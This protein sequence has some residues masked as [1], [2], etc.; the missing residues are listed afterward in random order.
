MNS[1]LRV[2]MITSEWPSPTSPEA[3]SAP[4]V[5]RQVDFLRQSGIAVEVF[6]FQG[7]KKLSNYLRAWYRVQ[8]RLSERKFDLVHAQFGQSAFPAL[9]KRLPLVI[10]F[11][12]SDLEGIVGD[13]GRYTLDGWGLRRF[14]Q[15][16]ARMADWVIVV[17]EHM[18][19]HL[20]GSV[21]ISVIPS[22]VD[23]TLFRRTP[24]EEAKR[25]LG[26]PMRKPL[27]LFV[28][29]PAEIRKRYF[30]AENAVKLLGESIAAELVVAWDKPH[31]SIPLYMSA[32]DVLVFTSMHEGSP[33]AVKEAL[34]CDLPIV[35]V[36]VGDVS[37]RLKGIEGCLV[38]VDDQPTTIAEA[39]ERVL[40]RGKRIRGRERILDLDESL[41][42]QKVVDIYQ[43]VIAKRD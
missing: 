11:R 3:A 33:N 15:I 29:D 35:S 18:T 39:L 17:S 40:K 22:G 4:F 27:V 6:H 12:G 13:D 14:G 23:L 30:L 2:L 20:R 9:P 32:C 21:P 8:K 25:Q 41:L 10:T 38:C 43:S 31:A 24:K 7:L 1:E 26:L 37:A 42:T 36:A 16:A 28:G 34:A 5:V 19:R